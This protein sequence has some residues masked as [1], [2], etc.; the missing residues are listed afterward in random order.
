MLILL[1]RDGVINTN[2]PQSVLHINAFEFLPRSLDAIAM[3]TSAGMTL[4]ICT[5]QSC[6]GRKLISADDLNQIHERMLEKIRAHG[7]D[8]ARIY[9]APD[10][11]EHATC[12]R[13]PGDG[14]LREALHDFSAKPSETP[15]IGDSLRDLQAAFSAGCPRLLVRTGN[16]AALE[17]RGLPEALLPVSI[18]DDLF[19]AA[20]HVLQSRQY[21]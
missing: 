8:I 14:M 15:F 12:R 4:A 21:V 6:V 19:A 20:T 1:D 11:P 13:K 18:V 2:L 7:G 16:G 5:N 10:A 17:A 9:V 3:L